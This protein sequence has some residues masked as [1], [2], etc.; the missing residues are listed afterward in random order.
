MIYSSNFTGVDVEAC[1]HWKRSDYIDQLAEGAFRRQR[2]DC[3]AA[4]LEESV[5]AVRSWRSRA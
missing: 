3:S 5:S 2:K 4:N 1:S